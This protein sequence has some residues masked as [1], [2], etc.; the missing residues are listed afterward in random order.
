MAKIRQKVLFTLAGAALWL[1]LFIIYTNAVILS[2]SRPQFSSLISA[3]T[4]TIALVFGGGMKDK[5]TM[6]DMQRARVVRGV[7]LYQ[8]HK[9]DKLLMTGDD[10]AFRVDEVDAMRQYAIDHGVPSADVAVDPHGYRTYDSCYRANSIFH[11][12]RV[13]AV[14]QPF[15]LPRI[16]YLC[17][18][19][20]V[21]IMPVAAED[22]LPLYGKT[23]NEVREI[24]ARVKAWLDIE[25]LHPLPQVTAK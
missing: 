10:G 15:H 6:S 14:S 4:S 11:L 21:S 8:A 20:G 9:V 2:S 13:V 18:H 19:L 23:R 17:S 3:P 16:E 5:N 24:L 22:N 12:T 1:V 25:I 7:E